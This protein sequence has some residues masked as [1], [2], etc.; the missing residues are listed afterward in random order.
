MDAHAHSRPAPAGY[1]H[2]PRT[3]GPGEPGPATDA[4]PVPTDPP[5]LVKILVA[6]ANGVGKSSLLAALSD[7]PPQ[8]AEEYVS[9]TA[10]GHPAGPEA[11][12]ALAVGRITLEGA[13]VLLLGT[14]ADASL[15]WRWEE[16][17]HD[18]I[19]AVVV[20]DVHRPSDGLAALWAFEEHGIPSLIAVTDFHGLPVNEQ[21]IRN[22][23]C[24]GA[25]PDRVH[26]VLDARDRAAALSVLVTLLELAVARA[27]PQPPAHSSDPTTTEPFTPRS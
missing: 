3:D 12:L 9:V 13:A 5:L 8:L 20:V 18:A 14:P 10:P 11:T 25:G 15:W 24:L 22:D 2:P 19:G 17:L 4:E 7:E 6:G 26:L 1:P 23:L 27:S 21:Q 16:L